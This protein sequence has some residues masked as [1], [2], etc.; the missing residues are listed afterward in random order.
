MQRSRQSDSKIIGFQCKVRRRWYTFFAP[1][2]SYNAYLQSFQG[3]KI[4]MPI[5]D[6]SKISPTT[7]YSDIKNINTKKKITFVPVKVDKQYCYFVSTNKELDTYIMNLTGNDNLFRIEVQVEDLEN[8]SKSLQSLK[9]DAVYMKP[10]KS[11]FRF[12]FY[13][14][15]K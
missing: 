3:P 2:V 14:P 1:N 5:I 10:S 8:F 7:F 13:M 9:I 11:I 15:L 4:M 6:S 12:D